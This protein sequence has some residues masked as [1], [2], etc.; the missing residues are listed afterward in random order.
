MDE[1]TA[2]KILAG[3]EIDTGFS[4]SGGSFKVKSEIVEEIVKTIKSKGDNITLTVQDFS[5]LIE[6]DVSKSKNPIL[7]LQSSFN[8]AI[9]RDYEPYAKKGLRVSIR[10]TKGL[11]ALCMNLTTTEVIK[12]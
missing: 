3:A 6:K 2:N 12:R 9:E 1:K 5:D 4:K 11:V 10:R 7:S 8:K